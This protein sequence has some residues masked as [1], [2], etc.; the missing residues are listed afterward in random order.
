MEV[1][2]KRAVEMRSCGGIDWPHRSV[3]MLD[4]MLLGFCWT[5]ILG[6]T[7]RDEGLILILLFLEMVR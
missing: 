5:D 1:Q 3:V 2:A 6:L 4:R 7:R